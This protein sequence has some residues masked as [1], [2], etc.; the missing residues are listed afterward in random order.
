[1]TIGCARENAGFLV[2][3]GEASGLHCNVVMR[4]S[5]AGSWAL[6]WVVLIVAA[7]CA[8]DE[9]MDSDDWEEDINEGAVSEIS[10]SGRWLAPAS[11]LA[12]GDQQDVAYDDGPAWNGGRN[13]GGGLLPGARE[14]GEQLRARFR[15][16]SGVDGYAC[17]PNTANTSRLSL[18]GTGR[19]IDVFVPL[20]RGSADNTVGDAA[21]HWLIANAE[22]IGIQYIVW[23]RSSWNASRPRGSKLRTYTGP[24]PHNDHLHVEL[25]VAGASRRTAFFRGAATP[26]TPPP[27]VTPPPP[28]PTMPST[29]TP[30][31]PTP[32]TPTPAMSVAGISLRVTASGLNLRS[33]PGSG[34]AV[35]DVMS[36][37]ESVRVL[38]APVSGWWNV[39]YQGV[40]GWASST[41]LQTDATFNP[42]VCR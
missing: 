9:S 41:F 35:L 6:G 30:S 11:V 16:I 34:Y 5:A 10:V 8:A 23:D 19:A 14:I 42:A 4:R 12:L 2:I 18:H 33:G 15:G 24:H 29:P 21:A 27:A 7:G 13:C 28:T 38:R 22:A 37:G 17:R 3:R 31:T 20:F 26:V 39:S 1:M 32:S 25:T 36:C 40:A